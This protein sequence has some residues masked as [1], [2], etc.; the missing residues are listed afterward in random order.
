MKINCHSHFHVCMRVNVCMCW[1]VS[2]SVRLCFVGAREGYNGLSKAK[3]RTWL[4][5]CL[6]NWFMIRH[7]YCRHCLFYQVH[8]PLLLSSAQWQVLLPFLLYFVVEQLPVSTLLCPFNHTFSVLYTFTPQ[9]STPVRKSCFV[10]RLRLRRNLAANSL[11]YDSVTITFH[12]YMNLHIRC[13]FWDIF[14]II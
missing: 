6:H 10:S 13:K 1:M 9:R 8:V 11:S 4:C 14:F 5:F 3:Y 12:F 2:S 7:H